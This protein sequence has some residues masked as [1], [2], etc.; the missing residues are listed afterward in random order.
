MW[1]R[2][3]LKDLAKGR[4]RV[5]YWMGFL[6]CL[7]AGI[8][9]ADAGGSGVGSSIN[10]SYNV[11]NTY[12]R[13]GG[14]DYGWGYWIAILTTMMIIV[15]AAGVIVVLIGV[16]LSNPLTVGVK[17][18]YM[19]GREVKAS[20]GE[21]GNAFSGRYMNVVGVMFMRDLF[22]FLWSL[23]LVIPGII[24]SYEYRMIPY[25]LAE[26][27]QLDWHRAF[28][29]SREMMMGHKWNTFVL[30]LSFL[31]WYLLGALA[32]GIGTLFVYPY[33]AA[34]EAELYAVLRQDVVN[35][36]FTNTYELP[37]TGVF[38]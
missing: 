26:N 33:T 10:F 32:C 9:G 13:Y 6:V 19:V 27:P 18:F 2:A 8:L 21:L 22:I 7:L 17:R 16:F 25:I 14:Y 29:L 30:D 36:G 4:L 34:T 23:L 24:K 31:G 28:E 38:S 11:E 1:T 35:R 3:Q 12:R 15:A 37:G 20:F 5:N